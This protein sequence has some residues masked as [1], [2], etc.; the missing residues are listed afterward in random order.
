M[1]ENCDEVKR[2]LGESE[3]SDKQCEVKGDIET[4]EK[5]KL[6]GETSLYCTSRENRSRMYKK[7]INASS[8]LGVTIGTLTRLLT[9]VA[10]IE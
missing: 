1:K 8:A 10:Y 4:E 3:S 9:V 5:G 2:K 7:L 6:K